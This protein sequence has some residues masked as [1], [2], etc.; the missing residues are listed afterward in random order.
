MEKEAAAVSLFI[1]EG[2]NKQGK[3]AKGEISGS[4]LALVKA[5]LRIANDYVSLCTDKK[6][7]E[8]IY[9]LIKDEYIRTVDL[10]EQ[11]TGNSTLLEDNPTLLLSL[12]R[13]NPYLDPLNDIQ[14]IL[15]QRFRD[16]NLSKEERNT[17][18]SPLLRTINAIAAGMRNTG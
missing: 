4:T 14:V 3:R 10:V 18:L 16:E 17:W 1:W 9:Q 7:A 2:I 8:K 12:S 11:I 13:R 6:Q 5:D 15:L